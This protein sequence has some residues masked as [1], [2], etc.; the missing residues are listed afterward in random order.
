MYVL[1][2]NDF[3]FVGVVLV[4]F[5]SCCRGSV[6][7]IEGFI[8]VMFFCFLFLLDGVFVIYLNLFLW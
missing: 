3:I 2:D 7:Y 1:I 8:L 4:C 5:S 6:R